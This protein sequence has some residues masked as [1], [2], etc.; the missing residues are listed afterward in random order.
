MT[1]TYTTAPTTPPFDP[2]TLDEVST[3]RIPFTAN[4]LLAQ[5][6]TDSKGHLHHLPQGSSVQEWVDAA[7]DKA[8]DVV[9]PQTR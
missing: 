2:N 6:F 9:G 5:S 7:A 1:T 3:D 8:V 4:D